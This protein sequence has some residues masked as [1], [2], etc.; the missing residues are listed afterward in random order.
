M[1]EF[2]AYLKK[3][4]Y[5]CGVNILSLHMTDKLIAKN[6]VWL[7]LRMTIIMVINLVAVRFLRSC[8]GLG[9]E[10]YGVFN[11]VNGV[12]NLILCL[13][14]VLS[15]ASQRFFSV[16]LGKHDDVAL[17]NVFRASVRVSWLMIAVA[18]PLLESVGLWFV[19]SKMNYAPELFP[20]VMVSY[21]TSIVMFV[22]MLVQVPFLACVLAHEKMNVFAVISLAEA[23]MRFI[24]AIALPHCSFPHLAGYSIAI[25]LFS[26][27]STVAYI[28][29]CKHHFPETRRAPVTDKSVYRTLLSFSGWTM[30]GSLAGAAMIQGN[31]LLLNTYVGP[32]ANAALAIALQIYYAF[33]TLGNNVMTAVRPQMI[34]SYSQR[35]FD[36][37]WRLF[38]LSTLAVTALVSI[39]AVPLMIWMPQ[40]L[41]LWLGET[42]ALTVTFS[43]WLIV[44]SLVMLL[45][46]PITIIMEAAGRVKEYHVPVEISILLSVPVSWVMLAHGGSPV[47]VAYTLVGGAVVA[48]VVRLV[49]L[50]KYAYQ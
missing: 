44:L 23:V 33:C 25:A 32:V 6:A 45:G 4:Y 29:Y 5:L 42:T 46:N 20:Q 38:W 22:S 50:R 17:Q 12:V 13:N 14:T 10:G 24:I 28:I 34:M 30:F 18:V 9:E 31:T 2:F 15:A 1:Q 40:V 39:V 19:I 16:E 37:T 43:R 7:Y 26:V 35:R 47:V 48:H 41:T 36:D 27:M 49:V 21:Q 3:K 11:A 8:G